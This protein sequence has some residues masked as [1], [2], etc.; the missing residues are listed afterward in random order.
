MEEVPRRA[1]TGPTPF[2]SL[3]PPFGSRSQAE[4]VYYST[5]GTL[6]IEFKMQK[7]IKWKGD[8]NQRVYL[9]LSER[10]GDVAAAA[11]DSAAN[12]FPAPP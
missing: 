4:S 7:R 10:M 2:K 3:S 1:W 5:E 6:G 12:S 8:C 9:C 11:N